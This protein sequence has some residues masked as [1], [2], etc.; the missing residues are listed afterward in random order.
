LPN[1]RRLDE[2]YDPA[3]TFQ[4]QDFD[5][6]IWKPPHGQ[7]EVRAHRRLTIA[8]LDGANVECWE[9]VAREYFI[10]GMNADEAGRAPQHRRARPSEIIKDVA[11][12]YAAGDE[13]RLATAFS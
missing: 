3:R 9:D 12:L 1:Y 2:K 5:R 6:R 8:T 7:Y 4:I 11:R 10:F 13:D